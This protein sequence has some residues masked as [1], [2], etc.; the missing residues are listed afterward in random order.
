[1]DF[2]ILFIPISTIWALQ[3]TLRRKVTILSV[4]AF[5]LVSVTVAIIRLPVLISVT[6]ATT[7]AS[8][9]VGK[10]IIV[11]AFEV[12][13]AVVAVNLPSLKSLWTQVRGWY[14]SEASGDSSCQRPYKLSAMKIDS[15]KRASTGS[16]TRLERGDSGHE[17]EEELCQS[18]TSLAH[19]HVE[20]ICARPDAHKRSS[21]SRL[22]KQNITVTTEVDVQHD[23]AR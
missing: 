15:R 5:G 7:D 16:I 14:T 10:M 22:S 2:Y 6:S 21:G 19:L 3:M 17:S 11:A 9:D 12:Q 18:K 23:D 1:M 4:L 8:V 13:C 20:E